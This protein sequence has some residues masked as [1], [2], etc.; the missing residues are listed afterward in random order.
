LRADFHLEYFKDPERL[1]DAWF[2]DS[3][4]FFSEQPGLCQLSVS[5]EA[6]F[7]TDGAQCYKRFLSAWCEVSSL[8]TRYKLPDNHPE[9]IYVPT[10][11]P[12][13]VFE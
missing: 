5:A 2:S 9:G 6:L 10:F 4:V 11:S 13:L 12:S 3:R 7:Q 1:L 8:E